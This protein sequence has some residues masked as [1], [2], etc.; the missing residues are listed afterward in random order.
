MDCVLQ[1]WQTVGE[2]PNK[3]KRERL[4]FTEPFWYWED[5]GQADA[6][7]AHATGEDVTDG[8]EQP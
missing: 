3:K 4:E 5:E 7:W 6:P 8:G 2:T 1:V